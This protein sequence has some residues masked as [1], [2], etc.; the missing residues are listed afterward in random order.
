MNVG[1]LVSVA[2]AMAELEPGCTGKG[3]RGFH[4]DLLLVIGQVM[5]LAI[6]SWLLRGVLLAGP[7]FPSFPFSLVVLQVVRG[8]DVLAV[9]FACRYLGRRRAVEEC[10]VLVPFLALCYLC[11]FLPCPILMIT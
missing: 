9:R 7:H 2:A 1:A 11:W 10:I 3:T 4:R 6:P 8:C 5:V